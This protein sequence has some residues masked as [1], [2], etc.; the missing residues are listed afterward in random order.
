V[1]KTSTLQTEQKNWR[2]SPL[3][4]YIVITV[5]H[6]TQD[7][8]FAIKSWLKMTSLQNIVKQTHWLAFHY[9]IIFVMISY[10]NTVKFTYE[11]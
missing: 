8:Q 2:K 5:F 7:L 9:I 11:N 3:I 6:S 10:R 1:T 4:P